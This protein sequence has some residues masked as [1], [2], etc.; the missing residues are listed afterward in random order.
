MD[1]LGIDEI[2][3]RTKNQI[4]SLRDAIESG[5]GQS[6]FR[7]TKL[8]LYNGLTSYMNN[9]RTYKSSEDKMDSILLGGDSQKKV[10]VGYDY[11]MAV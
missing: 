5:V 3:T 4:I 11:L 1:L 2:S 10:Q 6:Q 9:D 8:W 7:G